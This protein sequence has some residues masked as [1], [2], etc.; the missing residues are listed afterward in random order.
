M[1]HHPAWLAAGLLVFVVLACNL[2]K[3]AP[4]TNNNVNRDSNSNTEVDTGS[5]NYI[6]EIHMARDNGRG[7][8]GAETTSFAPNDRTIHC[9]CKTE[10]GQVRN[11][12]AFLL[13]DR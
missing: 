8:P 11:R 10:G 12:D 5:G 3:K 4:N 9:C 6:S 2:G 1:K 7:A 13:V